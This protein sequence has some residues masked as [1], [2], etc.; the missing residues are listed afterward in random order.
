MTEVEKTP[1]IRLT[2]ED[3]VRYDREI[4]EFNRTG[5]F[6]DKNGVS[7]KTYKPKKQGKKGCWSAYL[8]MSKAD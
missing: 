5:F 3:Q 4:E 2:E 7:S 8:R 6:T 1:Y